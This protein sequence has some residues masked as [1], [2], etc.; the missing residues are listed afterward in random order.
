MVLEQSNLKPNLLLDTVDGI[1][2]NPAKIEMMK[3]GCDKFAKKDAG[4]NI[5]KI[6]LKELVKK[7]KN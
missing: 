2:D 7:Y 1:L 4:L 6:I 5:A 3:A